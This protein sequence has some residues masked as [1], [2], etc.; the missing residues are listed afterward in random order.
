MRDDHERKSF[1][2]LALGALMA[3]FALSACDGEAQQAQ[4][5]PAPP[6]P[7]VAV[8]SVRSEDVALTYEYAGRVTGMREVE[9]RARVGGILLERTYAE[10]AVVAQG[11]LLF[12]SE[13]RRVGKG[14]V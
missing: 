14:C 2:C 10:G 13:E 11:D 3:A 7:E 12:R 8:E 9:V 1:P 4:A 6:P 5:Q